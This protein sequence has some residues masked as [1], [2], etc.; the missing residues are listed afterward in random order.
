M[1]LFCIYICR[2]A[3]KHEQVLIQDSASFSSDLTQLVSDV[4]MNKVHCQELVEKVQALVENSERK[5]DNSIHVRE[6]QING[7]FL[8][9]VYKWLQNWFELKKRKYACESSE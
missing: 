7:N 4:K 9:Y 2:N 1:W 8:T 3:V 6:T 5:T